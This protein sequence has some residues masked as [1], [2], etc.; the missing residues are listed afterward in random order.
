MSQASLEERYVS[1]P[2][3]SASRLRVDDGVA[4]PPPS[5]LSPSAWDQDAPVSSR[6]AGP[7]GWLRAVGGGVM[8]TLRAVGAVLGIAAAAI[9]VGVLVAIQRL[10]HLG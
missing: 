8:W 10:L 3:R 5:T 6:Q 2:P 4:P 1:M 9:S 7:L